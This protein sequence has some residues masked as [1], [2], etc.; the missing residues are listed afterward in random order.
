MP[1][2]TGERFGH[3]FVSYSRS[4]KDKLQFCRRHS[5]LLRDV[6]WVDDAGIDSSSR[7][8]RAVVEKAI[9]DASAVFALCSPAARESENVTA[10]LEIAR[11]LDKPVHPIW[12]EGDEWALS[13]PFSLLAANYTDLRGELWKKLLGLEEL[14]TSVIS[15]WPVSAQQRGDTVSA[16]IVSKYLCSIQCD[17]ESDLILTRPKPDLSVAEFLQ[18]VYELLADETLPPLSYGSAWCLAQ[19]K[20]GMLLLPAV[21]AVA[22][23]EPVHLLASRWLNYRCSEVSVGPGSELELLRGKEFGKSASKPIGLFTRGELRGFE[24]R[25]NGK[26]PFATEFSRPL[27]ADDVTRLERENAPQGVLNIAEAVAYV[28]RR[29]IRSGRKAKQDDNTTSVKTLTPSQ[30]YQLVHFP[31]ERF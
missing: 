4:D 10:E 2:I 3:V 14:A 5:D 18:T 12:F 31:L 6:L 9:R 26:M 11:A 28:E 29:S 21:W 1:A 16:K 15:K 30:V 19:K 8:W 20:G 25:F 13:A 24:G 27:S 23:F 22:Q 7:N 17:K